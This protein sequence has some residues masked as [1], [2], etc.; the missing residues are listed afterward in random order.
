[1]S[2]LELLVLDNGS[3]YDDASVTSDD[4]SEHH[5]Y[6]DSSSDEEEENNTF[7]AFEHFIL[8]FVNGE[9]DAQIQTAIDS[10]AESVQ[11]INGSVGKKASPEDSDWDTVQDI[12]RSNFQQRVEELA[13]GEGFGADT[14]V[15]GNADLDLT[16]TKHCKHPENE[17]ML[18]DSYTD[19]LESIWNDFEEALTRHNNVEFASLIIPKVE[20]IGS[21]M[22][23]LARTLKGRIK[24]SLVFENILIIFLIIQFNIIG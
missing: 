15:G 13:E 1:M 9:Y 20:L 3:D 2:N 4:G 19:S 14:F 8:N 7:E 17:P 10:Y 16:F 21:T 18:W 12:S 23:M 11:A 5:S 22:G 24:N 6:Y